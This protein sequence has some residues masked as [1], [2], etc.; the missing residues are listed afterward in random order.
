VRSQGAVEQVRL[1]REMRIQ[2][3]VAHASGRR[4]V[5]DTRAVIATGREDLGCRL[6]QPLTSV[7]SGNASDAAHTEI[8]QTFI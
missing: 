7:S 6:Q 4:D 5:G 8:K 2:R 1:R 3:A